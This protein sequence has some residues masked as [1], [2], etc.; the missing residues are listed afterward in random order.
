MDFVMFNNMTIIWFNINNIINTPYL[1]A[2]SIIHSLITGL[3]SHYLDLNN[4]ILPHIGLSYS[5]YDLYSSIKTNKKDF[6]IHGSIYFLFFLY[7]IINNLYVPCNL[8]LKINTSSIFYNLSFYFK[9]MYR[10]PYKLTLYSLSSLLFVIL[11]SY[12]RLILFPYLSYNYIKNIYIYDEKYYITI[13]GTISIIIL[14]LYWFTYIIKKL[15]NHIFES[16]SRSI[17]MS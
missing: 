13:I 2:C 1:D 16:I 12:Y 15:I 8:A 9:N 5:V 3:G 6:I 4:R 10:G 14:N 7:F 11:F 17:P